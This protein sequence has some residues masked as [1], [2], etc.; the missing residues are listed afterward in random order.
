MLRIVW[1]GSWMRILL[2][3]SIWRVCGIRLSWEWGK[4][5]EG[6]LLLDE[7]AMGIVLLDGSQ[8]GMEKCMNQKSLGRDYVRIS[9][10]FGISLH[11]GARG[12]KLRLQTALR[13]GRMKMTSQCHIKSF[14][15]A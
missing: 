11:S 5:E 8:G 14:C 4:G 1:I 3:L 12:C 10:A 9:R 7:G 15:E 2:L 6:H 13:N